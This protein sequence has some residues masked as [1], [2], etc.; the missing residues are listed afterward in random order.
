MFYTCGSVD[1]RSLPTGGRG[2]CTTVCRDQK[3]RWSFLYARIRHNTIPVPLAL[4]TRS[5][6][7]L[8]AVLCA[9]HCQRRK[10]DVCRK[11]WAFVGI[12]RDVQSNGSGT[13]IHL[14][15]TT[16]ML[17]GRTLM[18]KPDLLPGAPVWHRMEK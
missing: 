9:A 17:K 18:D 3:T 7:A 1:P 15:R 6:V 8:G 2:L 4:L 11:T 10:L 12:L 14:S 16:Q 5:R 13:A